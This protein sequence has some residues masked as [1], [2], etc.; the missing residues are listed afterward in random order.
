MCSKS[1]LNHRR[2]RFRIHC[3]RSF[4]SSSGD[5]IGSGRW[6]VW[7]PCTTS[8]FASSASSSASQGHSST[9][10]TV[11]RWW[12]WQQ[13]CR[14]GGSRR[15]WWSLLSDP[16]GWLYD[17]SLSLS[18]SLLSSLSISITHRGWRREKRL[19]VVLFGSYDQASLS[20]ALF[21]IVLPSTY[22]CMYLSGVQ[23]T[24]H[25]E[26]WTGDTYHDQQACM[27]NGWRFPSDSQ[28]L[29]YLDCCEPCETVTVCW[30]WDLHRSVFLAVQ[31]L[32]HTC[33]LKYIANGETK[34][35]RWG[36]AM[37]FVLRFCCS[38]VLL[39]SLMCQHKSMKDL[40]MQYFT[41][42]WFNII[43]NSFFTL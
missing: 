11:G 39:A 12:R 35:E 20:V 40:L 32:H 13:L 22:L 26:G 18:L 3:D 7:W 43:K 19:S 28:S 6:W 34:R 21:F 10:S 30:I 33:C 38:N 2:E 41:S 24:R 36:S 8:C 23:E 17:P 42:L 29:L 9:H 14:F 5:H 15:W 37:Y 27:C 16:Q 25:D 4:W 1:G 31:Q